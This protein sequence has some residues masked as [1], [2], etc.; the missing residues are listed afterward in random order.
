M[1]QLWSDLRTELGARAGIIGRVTAGF[2]TTYG[3]WLLLPWTTYGS[4]PTFTILARVFPE[5]MMGALFLLAGLGGGL[6]LMRGSLRIWRH[7][8][9]TQGGLLVF[10]ALVLGWGNLASGAFNIYGWLGVGAWL[11]W[12]SLGSEMA[13]RDR[14]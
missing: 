4:S 12:W 1:G 2:C 13:R 9:L 3:C 6:A 7:Y 10:Y 11:A 5:P 8:L 14:E